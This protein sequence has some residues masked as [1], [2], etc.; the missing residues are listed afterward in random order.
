MPRKARRE[1][2]DE[3]LLNV[4]NIVVREDA[5]LVRIDERIWSAADFL[6]LCHEQALLARVDG[7]GTHHKLSPN[8]VRL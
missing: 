5:N 2:K 1:A 6:Q 3:L 4:K 7:S 8:E